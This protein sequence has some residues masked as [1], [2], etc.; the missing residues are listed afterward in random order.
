MSDSV[1]KHWMLTISS[2]LSYGSCRKT[3]KIGVGTELQ[4]F[5]SISWLSEI[6][7]L[8]GDIRHVDISYRAMQESEGVSREG[9]DSGGVYF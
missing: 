8:F 2:V 1:T 7:H 5:K 9:S 6:L 3:R 4:K